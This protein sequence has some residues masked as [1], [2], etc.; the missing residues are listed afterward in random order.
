VIERETGKLSAKVFVIGDGAL[1][2]LLG[3]EWPP[4]ADLHQA[5]NVEGQEPGWRSVVFSVSVP[6]VIE[7][8]PLTIWFVVYQLGLFGARTEE[9][10]RAAHGFDALLITHRDDGSGEIDRATGLIRQITQVPSPMQGFQQVPSRLVWLDADPNQA[11]P[12]GFELMVEMG[13]PVAHICDDTDWWSLA[14]QLGHEL[15]ARR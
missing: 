8:K 9:I 10:R 12:P 11:G 6:V 1:D 2:H 13:L 3:V 4:E 5:G 14:N 15:A 7:G